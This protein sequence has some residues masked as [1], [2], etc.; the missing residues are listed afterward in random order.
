VD[1]TTVGP[2]YFKTFGI[3]LLQG[4]DFDERDTEDGPQVAII[5][6]AMAR[7]CWPGE[8]P[9][10][11]RFHQDGLDGP[12]T[13]VVGVCRDYN[14]RTIGEEPRPYVHW[15]QTQD[16]SSSPNLVV[17]TNGDPSVM[18]DRLRREMLAMDPNLVFTESDTMP[19]LI[20]VTLIPVRMGAVLIG[21]FGI[22]GMLLAAVG[23]YGVIAYSVGRRT[24]E[25][26]LRIAL[27]AETGDV[28]K[29]VFRQGIL[30]V[31]VGVALGCLGALAGSRVLGSVLYGISAF[32]PVSFGLASV[33]LLAVAFLANWL[34]ARRA[35]RIDPMISLRYE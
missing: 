1:Q 30:I 2:D 3:P 9:I 10:G 27:G 21:L 35:A 18:V 19:A 6:E 25:I 13:E 16:Y 12:A 34:P 33:V 22:L 17:R 28:L 7:T 29:M 5:N 14:V 23:L 8:D 31:L 20:E 26:G 24:R 4:R 11:K 32:D 15:A